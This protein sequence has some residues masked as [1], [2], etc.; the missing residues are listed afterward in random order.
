MSHTHD[1]YMEVS[2]WKATQLER[3]KINV[4]SINC[5]S[6]YEIND[7]DYNSFAK[8][9]GIVQPSCRRYDLFKSL[10]PLFLLFLLT[11]KL[12]LFTYPSCTLG[13]YIVIV[14]RVPWLGLKLLVSRMRLLCIYIG[15]PWGP[16]AWLVW[17]PAYTTT[18]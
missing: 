2:L 1:L 10:F 17:L 3:M 11:N 14:W 12:S 8:Y 4:P 9:L 15:L 18:R 13:G 6:Y 7:L 16:V 5:I